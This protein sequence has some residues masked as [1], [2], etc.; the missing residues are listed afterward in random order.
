MKAF[1]LSVSLCLFVLPVMGA[2]LDGA[3]QQTYVSC[4]GIS[5]MLSDVK[6][7]AGINTAVTG[8]GTVAGGGA[9]VAGIK[10]KN[11]MS[12]LYE[13]EDNS[14][15]IQYDDIEIVHNASFKPNLKSKKRALGNW[16]TG[17]LTVNTATNVAGAVI[18]TKTLNKDDDLESKIQACIDSVD[19][20]QSV[21]L[22]AK[23]ENIDINEAKSIYDAC[24]DWKYVDFSVLRKRAKGTQITTAAGG[25]VGGVGVITSVLAN[26]AKTTDKEQKLDTASNVLAGGATLLSGGATVFN[27]AQIVAI[28]KIVNIADQCEGVLK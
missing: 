19:N 6:K 15:N 21:M 7:L 11:L 8:V 26:N 25:V 17:L 27:V 13:I 16:R 28:K 3:L 5:D 2:D 18:A 23:F 9:L 24:S 1:I 14:D 10:K 20:L 4:V 12:R 22:A